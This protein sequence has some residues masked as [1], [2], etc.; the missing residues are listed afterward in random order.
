[1]SSKLVDDWGFTAN[2]H[3]SCVV[4]KTIDGEQFTICWH[5][6]NL[7][8]SDV[9][10]KVMDLLIS[11]M[12]EEFGQESP[13]NV[14]HGKVHDHLGMNFDFSM[15]GQVKVDM[16]DCIKTVPAGV[17]DDMAGKSTTPATSHLFNVS[18]HPTPVDK[19]KAKVFH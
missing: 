11:M 9:N 1:M 12:E 5:V 2:L 6:D 3:D 19:E 8:L 13:M 18:D 16:I 17:P 15:P 10:P 7:K 14:S 4:N